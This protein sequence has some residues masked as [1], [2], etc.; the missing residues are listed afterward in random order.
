M[1]NERLQRFYALLDG[2]PSN[3]HN[4][5][6]KNCYLVRLANGRYAKGEGTY[7]STNLIENSASVNIANK[8]VCQSGTDEKQ[9]EKARTFLKRIGV[10]DFNERDEFQMLLKQHYSQSKP[11]ITLEE[12]IRHLKKFAKF[13]QDK[14]QETAIFANSFFLRVELPDQSKE[15]YS[16]PRADASKF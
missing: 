9:K 2:V 14:P 1:S 15:H 7:F 12:N 13:L 3:Y 6:V 10:K 11:N 5:Q 8:K 16:Q 4:S